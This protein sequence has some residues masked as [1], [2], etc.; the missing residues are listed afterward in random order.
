MGR[1]GGG[2]GFDEELDVAEV[3]LKVAFL[4]GFGDVLDFC[5]LVD[6]EGGAFGEGGEG[7]LQ[8]GGEE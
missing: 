3:G 6:S 1:R 4:E 5:Y 7:G 2:D 8:E